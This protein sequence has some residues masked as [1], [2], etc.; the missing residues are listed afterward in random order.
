M[1]RSVLA[2]LAVAMTLSACAT[3]RDSRVNPFNWFGRAESEPVTVAPEAATTDGRQLADQIISLNVDRTPGGAILRAVAL[4]PTQGYWEAQLVRV[5][6]DTPADLIYEFRVFPPLERRR[7]GTQRSREIIAG[8]ALSNVALQNVRTITVLG[9][10][11]RLTSR[12]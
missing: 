5:E 8:A 2:A 6:S 3:I 12:R 1:S 7:Q 11:N 9:Q 4:P 10:R